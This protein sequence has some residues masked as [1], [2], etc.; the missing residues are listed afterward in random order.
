MKS[1]RQLTE[2]IQ[3]EASSDRL[4]NIT[5]N[6]ADH[7]A[8]DSM[9][10]AIAK[11]E[12]FITI[13]FNKISGSLRKVMIQARFIRLRRFL[14]NQD[15]VR[16]MKKHFPGSE[17]LGAHLHDDSQMVPMLPKFNTR[18]P[19]AGMLFAQDTLEESRPQSRGQNELLSVPALADSKECQCCGVIVYLEV[20][21]EDLRW[22]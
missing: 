11:A 15:F 1:L 5:D 3:D 20:S 21:Y 18:R 8:K 9:N 13:H 10:N 19:A 2:W 22:K 12:T 7:K 6:S 17:L 4:Y 16:R 14:Y